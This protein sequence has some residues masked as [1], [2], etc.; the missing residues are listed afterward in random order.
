MDRHRERR[1]DHDGCRR[2]RVSATTARRIT[3]RWPATMCSPSPARAMRSGLEVSVA[4]CAGWMRT[5]RSPISRPMKLRPAA[6]LPTTCFRSLSITRACCGSAPWQGWRATTARPCSAVPPRRAKA[7]RIYS[8][9]VDGDTLWV[10]TSEGMFRRDAQEQWVVPAWSPMFARPNAVITMVSAGDGEYWLGGQGGLWRTEGDGAPAPVGQDPQGDGWVECCRPCCASPMAAC[11]CRCRRAAWVICDRIGVA[12][13]HSRPRRAWAAAC[14]AALPGRVWWRVADKQQGE[15]GT[16]G[17]PHRRNH[18][19]CLAR[20]SA[21]GRRLMSVLE[22]RSG[23]LWLGYGRGWL[24]SICPA[25]PCDSWTADAATDATPAAGPV[26]WLVETAGWQRVAVR[27]RRRIAAP[28]RRQR[29]GARR[30][31]RR[32]RTTA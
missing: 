22:D 31:H 21:E 7:M 20:G 23:R 26:D 32:I 2:A 4:G 10:G 28:R 15:H 8:L 14:T 3:R 1:A 17:Y 6:C 30:H 18:A 25:R 24:A 13:P 11:G 27:A 19:H 29:Q 9:T 12:S 5:G 16:A